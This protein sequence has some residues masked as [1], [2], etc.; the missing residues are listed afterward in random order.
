MSAGAPRGGGGRAYHIGLLSGDVAEELLLVGDPARAD[1][2]AARFDSVR[3]ST[4]CREY[5]T[6]TGP[7]RGREISVMATGMGPDNTEIAL[8]ELKPLLRQPT[9]IRVGTTGALQRDIQLGELVISLEALRIESVTGFWVEPEF[10]AR[11]SSVVTEA[12]AASARNLKVTVHQGLTAT[13][14]SFYGAQGRSV[15]AVVPR[16]RGLLDRLAAQGVL[17]M[18]M[19]TSVLFVLGELLGMRT[20]AVCAV[21]GNRAT[22]SFLDDPVAKHAAEDRATDV[23][24]GAL[25]ALRPS[26]GTGGGQLRPA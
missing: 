18:E 11:A 22:D 23:A 10:K 2:I 6:H 13:A 14:P 9:V 5:V 3:V 8:V 17:N 16:D 7:F 19:E 25:D 26:A 24:L 15:G 20:G 1:R 4:R 12:L 21:I